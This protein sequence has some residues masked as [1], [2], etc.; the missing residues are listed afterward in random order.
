[1][2]SRSVPSRSG[3]AARTCRSSSQLLGTMQRVSTVSRILAFGDEQ[4]V[5]T[6]VASEVAATGA[7]QGCVALAVCVDEQHTAI[8]RACLAEHSDQAECDV[9][10]RRALPHAT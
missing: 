6:V 9:G 3:E 7:D 8:C 1:M 10:G 2:S 4:R 5:E